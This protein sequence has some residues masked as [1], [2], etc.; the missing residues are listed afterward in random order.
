MQQYAKYKKPSPD[1]LLPL[2]D[3][4]TTYSKVNEGTLKHLVGKLQVKEIRKG[5]KLYDAGE[6]CTHIY[7]VVKGI[8][9]GYIID[10]SKEVTTWITSENAMVASIKSFLLQAPTEENIA[11]IED[12]RLVGIHY[13]DLQYMYDTFPDFNTAG[14]RITEYYYTHAESRAFLGRLSK[15]TDRYNYFMAN[16]GDV[17]NRIP[18]TYIASYLGIRL[19]SLSRIRKR[20]LSKK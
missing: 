16:N 9:R 7:F 15:A 6:I 14:R 1:E 5:D 11:A 20:L 10:N 18:L 12:C 3:Y 4:I 13:T 17:I 19:D 2:V 8:L